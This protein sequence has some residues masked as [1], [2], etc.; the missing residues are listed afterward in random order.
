MAIGDLSG[1]R[2][3][4]ERAAASGSAA[5]ARAMAETY[6]PR[7]LAERRVVGFSPDP[8]AALAW[9]RRAAALGLARDVAPAIARLEA[10]R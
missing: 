8:V 7:L 4:F 6:D 3:F 5:A 10:A 9:Y 2:L 1:A